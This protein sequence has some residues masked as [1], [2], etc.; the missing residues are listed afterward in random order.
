M[1]KTAIV[2]AASVLLAWF[3]LYFVPTRQL[4]SMSNWYALIG[5][6]AAIGIM[7]ILDLMYDA[8]VLIFEKFLTEGHK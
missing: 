4:I 8:I 1:L 5:G 2:F 7:Y 6:L 3:L